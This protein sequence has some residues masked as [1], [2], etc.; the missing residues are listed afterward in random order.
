[1]VNINP[2]SRIDSELRSVDAEIERL[3]AELAAA[4]TKKTELGVAKRILGQ[5]YDLNH[6][7][8][9]QDEDDDGGKTIA[10]E[11]TTILKKSGPLSKVEIHQ[12]LEE[13]RE[14]NITTVSTTLSR[15]RIRGEVDNESGK[16]LISR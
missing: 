16:W 2:L 4:Q 1:M 8:V 3:T 11:I 15:M 13:L 6:G 7:A 12:Q 5:I 10:D 9:A 14:V